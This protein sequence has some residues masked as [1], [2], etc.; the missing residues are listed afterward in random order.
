MRKEMVDQKDGLARL[1]VKV[2][3]D[4]MKRVTIREQEY[5]YYNISNTPF[6]LGIVMPSK[7]GKYRVTGGIELNQRRVNG[8]WE[9]DCL[10]VAGKWRNFIQPTHSF[11]TTSGSFIP[12]GFIV[13]TTMLEL[14]IASLTH[15]KRT[16]STSSTDWPTKKQA[17][18]GVKT[19]WGLCQLVKMA[20]D[21]TGRI[22][23]NVSRFIIKTMCGNL[24]R[25]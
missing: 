15:Q 6:T 24:A 1:T 20:T 17:S 14:M 9:V 12:T 3:M 25:P 8:E 2:H 4:D 10:K 7:Y 23:Q 13:N 16:W 11:L 5:F 18:T 19:G 21:T 22:V